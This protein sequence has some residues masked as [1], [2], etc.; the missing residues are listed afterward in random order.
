MDAL[1]GPM[2]EARLLVVGLV[3]LVLSGCSGARLDLPDHDLPGVYTDTDVRDE[4]RCGEL[5][6][7]Q[8]C[9]IVRV[10]HVESGCSPEVGGYVVCNAT[11]EWTADSG[12]AV[13]GSHLS[14]VAGGVEVPSCDPEPGSPC[15]VAGVLHSTRHFDS[16][17]QDQTWTVAIEAVLDAPG[18]VPSTTGSFT[19]ELEMRI[20]TEGPSALTS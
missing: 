1:H 18:D 12:A 6:M 19:L 7:P 13:P 16:P 5:L 3:A 8:G 14:V 2:P 9:V 17:G 20:R 11:I 10:P 15:Q 4:F